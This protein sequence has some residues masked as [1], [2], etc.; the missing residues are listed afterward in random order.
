MT[1]SLSQIVINTRTYLCG[2]NIPKDLTIIV[3]ICESHSLRRESNHLP[4]K[5]H[6]LEGFV[7]SFFT[8]FGAHVNNQPFF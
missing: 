6:K 3:V 2:L 7:T 8:C 4:F 1:I 5:P